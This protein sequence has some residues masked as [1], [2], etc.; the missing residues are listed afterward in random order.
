MTKGKP[1]DKTHQSSK[2]AKKRFKYKFI[3]ISKKI[4]NKK[5]KAQKPKNLALKSTN[6]NEQIDTKN[7]STKETLKT[8]S[9]EKASAEI[10]NNLP[11][12][13]IKS[14]TENK[15]KNTEA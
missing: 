3:K 11:N 12:F 5:T 4:G 14:Y 6:P 9:S 13:D 7:I 10:E 1:R 15:N 8:N 2:D